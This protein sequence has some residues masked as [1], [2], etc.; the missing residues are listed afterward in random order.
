MKTGPEPAAVKPAVMR[1]K[2]KT[3]IPFRR[4]LLLKELTHFAISSKV[5]WRFPMSVMLKFKVDRAPVKIFGI[6]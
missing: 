1:G 2:P 6:V 3:I 4:L 5:S